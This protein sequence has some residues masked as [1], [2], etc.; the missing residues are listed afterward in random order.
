MPKSTATTQVV[1]SSQSPRPPAWVASLL[2]PSTRVIRGSTDVAIEVTTGEHFT[3]VS[4]T[5]PRADALS[6][7]ALHAHVRDAYLEIAAT[8]NA[9]QRHPLRFWNFVPRIH[10]PSGEGLDR[11]MVFNGGRFAACEH[12]HGS[13]NAFDH[14]LASASGVGVLGE[15]LAI[16]CLAADAAGEPVENPRQVPAYRYSRRYGPRPPCFARATRML[17]PV[18][19]AWWLLVAGT[20]SIRG[21]ETMHVGDIDAQMVETLDNLDALLEAAQVKRGQA[22]APSR[23]TSL[24]V[25][26]VRPDDIGVVRQRLDQRYGPLADLEFAQAELCRTDLLV[27]IEGIASL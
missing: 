1:L 10:T 19:G 6:P 9:Q 17:T 4:V 16:H 11:Y 15:A 23:L 20:A 3:H 25:Y 8:L 26:L 24:R 5:I 21:E 13:R 12:W 14:T 22:G 18:E 7:D 2:G 27:E